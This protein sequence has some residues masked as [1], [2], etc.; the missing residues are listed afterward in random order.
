[1]VWDLEQE[2]L[3]DFYGWKNVFTD[4]Y[5]TEAQAWDT[6]SLNTQFYTVEVAAWAIAFSD[7]TFADH[8]EWKTKLPVGIDKIRTF[9]GVS[10][11]VENLDLFPEEFYINPEDVQADDE[12]WTIFVEAD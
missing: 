7:F 10:E 4:F 11:A 12:D 9:L 1:M 3:A 8:D 2:N 5:I 6:E